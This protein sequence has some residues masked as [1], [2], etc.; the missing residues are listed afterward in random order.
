MGSSESPCSGRNQ[1]DHPVLPFVKSETTGG[2]APGAGWQGRVA[3]DAGLDAGLLIRADDVVSAAQRTTLP[4]AGI[5]VQDAPRLLGELRVAWEDPLL[6]S[7]WLDGI[8]TEDTPD[9]AGTHGPA[10][11]YGSPLGQVGGRQA[12]QRQLGLADGLT[13][14][15]LDDRSVARGKKRA[16]DPG[17][18][19]RPR[20]SRRTPNGVA[21]GARNSDAT[22]PMFQ[23][24]RSISPGIYGAGGPGEPSDAGREAQSCVERCTGIDRGTQAGTWAGPAVRGQASC[25]SIRSED[26][27]LTP[28][29]RRIGRTTRHHNPTVNCE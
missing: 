26:S 9:G 3:S 14:D 23:P 22:R 8:G 5:Q 19:D 6:V 28:K 21:T 20:R 25:D 4:G 13:R 18:L 10:Q 7:P 17:P 1:S 16:C 27:V 2:Q 24:R 12:A 15:R 29:A 11:G